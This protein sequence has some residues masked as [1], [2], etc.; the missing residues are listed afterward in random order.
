MPDQPLA[1]LFHRML[2]FFHTLHVASFKV[3]LADWNQQGMFFSHGFEHTFIHYVK[4]LLGS[5]LHMSK[6]IFLYQNLLFQFW[7]DIYACL[8]PCQSVF[9]ILIYIVK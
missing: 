4:T 9:C 8:I 2:R 6:I 7:Y 1:R 5:V 3:K